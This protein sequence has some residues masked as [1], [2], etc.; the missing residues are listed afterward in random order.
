MEL[1][2]KVQNFLALAL[3]EAGDGDARPACDDLVDL[4]FGDFVLQ[5]R[6]LTAGADA[7]LRIVELFFK[8]DKVAVLET[9]RLL[10]I[11]LLGGRLDLAAHGVDLFLE[12]L[13]G[14]DGALLLLPLRLHRG[15]LFFELEELFLELL[16][17]GDGEV[18]LLL[19]ERLL[20][21]FEL[22]DLA[23]QGIHLGGHG[24][25]LRAHHGG[26]FIDEVDRLVGEE[27]V[28]DVAVGERRRRDERVVVD[29]HAVEDLEA[30][31]EAAQDGDGV[32]HRGF[33]HHHGLETALER[34]VLF[35]V[36]AVLVERRRADAV[37]F[38][39]REEG[40]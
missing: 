33:T 31:L 17:A 19:G 36:L 22:H 39:A 29:A 25:D 27:P 4:L 9:G 35:D 5:K 38:A 16:V 24:V 1:F 34:G 12:V 11:A 23:V 6:I 10:V 30:L 2:G 26:R 7:L 37:Q 20:L 28:G 8:G 21:H 18:V 15:E 3:L 14:A 32:L 13:F 40:L